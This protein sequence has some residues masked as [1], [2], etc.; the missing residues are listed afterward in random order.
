MTGHDIHWYAVRTR[1]R[2][3]QKVEQILQRMRVETYLPL[4][5][6]WSPRLDRRERIWVPALPGYLFAQCVLKPELRATVKRSLGV[7]GLVENGG[8]PCIIPEEEIDSLRILLESESASEHPFFRVGDRVRVTS[9]PFV[10]AFG[11]LTRVEEKNPLL[12]VSVECVHRSFS[13]HVDL[14][15]LEREEREFGGGSS[16]ERRSPKLERAGAAAAL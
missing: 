16:R 5:R 15:W 6:A 14:R 12:V 4:R 7:M 8:K 13:V 11:Y 9:G 10:G 1:G 2:H 3:E